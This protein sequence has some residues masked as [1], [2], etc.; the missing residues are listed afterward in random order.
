MALPPDPIKPAADELKASFAPLV[1][2]DARVLVLGSLPGEASLAA[3]QYYAHPRNGF[4]RLMGAVIGAPLADLDYANRIATLHAHR[5]GL[6]DMV[7][8]ARRRGSLDQ[9]LRDVAANDLAALVATLPELR[10]VAFNGQKA[11]SLGLPLL[12]NGAAHLV[13]PSSSPANTLAFDKK[14]RLWKQLSTA[15]DE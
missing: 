11:A 7:A 2:S 1:R 10:L 14:C 6:W 8:T 4:W 9:S 5:I 13:L 3:G 15:F 12:P